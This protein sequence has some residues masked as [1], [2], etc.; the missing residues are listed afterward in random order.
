[1]TDLDAGLNGASG[2][3]FEWGEC[4]CMSADTRTRGNEAGTAST[5]TTFASGDACSRLF[6]RAGNACRHFGPTKRASI[7]SND[8]TRSRP[9]PSASTSD[10]RRGHPIRAACREA[11]APRDGFGTIS[12][13]D[14]YHSCQPDVSHP[15]MPSSHPCLMDGLRGILGEVERVGIIQL[16]MSVF[17]CIE[18]SQ[19]KADVPGQVKFE[20]SV[21]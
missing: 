5:A 1:M 7:P 6:M 8:H 15:E 18:L 16:P 19:P 17:I 11:Q 21:Y 20:V 3:Y 12:P 9:S 10:A 13:A 14:G 2:G 4:I